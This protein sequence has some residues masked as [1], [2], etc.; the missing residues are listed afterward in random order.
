MSRRPPRLRLAEVA[1][2]SVSSNST[3]ALKGDSMTI[4]NFIRLLAL[5]SL[6]FVCPAIPAAAQGVGAIGGTVMDASGAVL[7]G[8]TVTLSS[9]QRT[10]GSNQQAISDE[11]GEYQFIRLVPGTYTVK[12]ELQ[13]F[14]PSE[15]R[16]II[17]NADQ[18]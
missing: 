10:T 14:R 18:T 11:R 16:G 4:K 6:I 5:V 13:G 9:T 7:P 2:R 15:Q 8:V 17:V 1:D 12:G 3:T